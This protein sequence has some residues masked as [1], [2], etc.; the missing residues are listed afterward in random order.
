MASE[1]TLWGQPRALPG[2]SR[3]ASCTAPAPP[4]PYYAQWIPSKGRRWVE[5]L[6]GA[7][8][9]AESNFGTRIWNQAGPAMRV[10]AQAVE[11]IGE[12]SG[13][14]TQDPL[15]KSQVLYHLS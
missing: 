15:I 1:M 14:R 10:V 2:P 9:R 13:D 6:D 7:D 3:A 12:P 5:V 11:K 4:P 8:L